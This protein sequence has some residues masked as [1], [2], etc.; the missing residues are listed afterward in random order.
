MGRLEEAVSLSDRAE[1][2]S[3]RA[4]SCMTAFLLCTLLVLLSGILILCFL[5]ID[6]DKTTC[7]W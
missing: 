7:D 6:C 5:A 1:V 3:A 2:Y 4:I